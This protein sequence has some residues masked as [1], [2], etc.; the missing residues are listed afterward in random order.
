[1]AVSFEEESDIPPE[2][3]I[4]VVTMVDEIGR[5]KDKIIYFS[6]RPKATLDEPPSVMQQIA[7]SIMSG[8]CQNE[9]PK[10]ALKKSGTRP[11]EVGHVSWSSLEIK[12]FDLTLGDHPS[13]ISGPPVALNWD[14]VANERTIALDEY[15]RARLPRRHRRQLKLSNKHRRQVLQ[16]QFTDEQVN[17]AWSE[18]LQIRMQRRETLQRGPVAVMMDDAWESACRKYDRLLGGF[19][20][21]V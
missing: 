14:K 13:A 5:K 18:A 4:E 10:S 8:C 20:R 11:R 9:Y 21:C 12:E 15:E 6:S 3:G 19:C 2:G 16:E 7:N 1:M 17:Q